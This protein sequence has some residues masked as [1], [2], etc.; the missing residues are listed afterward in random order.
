MRRNDWGGDH[1]QDLCGAKRSK[2]CSKGSKAACDR[3]K[4]DRIPCLERWTC[5][6]LGA[7]TRRGPFDKRRRSIFGHG[8]IKRFNRRRQISRAGHAILAQRPKKR[9]FWKSR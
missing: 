6:A 3:C 2:T 8:K 1:T 9:E 5:N 7:S 4:L